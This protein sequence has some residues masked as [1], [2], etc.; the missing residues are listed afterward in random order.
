[1]KSLILTNLVF[2]LDRSKF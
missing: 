1:M 2:F